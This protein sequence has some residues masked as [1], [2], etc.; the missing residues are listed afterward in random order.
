MHNLD[1]SAFDHHQM[2]NY[3]KFGKEDC[4][5]QILL[6][7]LHEEEVCKTVS[8]AV[9]LPVGLLQRHQAQAPQ[10][11]EDRGQVHLGKQKL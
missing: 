6:L 9:T 2:L 3:S 4:H 5:L 8:Q 7:L 1:T 10:T 11:S